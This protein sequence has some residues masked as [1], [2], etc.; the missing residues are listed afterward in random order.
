MNRF[1]SLFGSERFFY[2]F[3]EA[4][5]SRIAR[6][7][8]FVRIVPHWLLPPSQRF[9]SSI[10]KAF[11]Q[12]TPAGPCPAQSSGTANPARRSGRGN[13]TR[14]SSA[15][16]RISSLRFDLCRMPSLG[17]LVKSS[18]TSCLCRPVF[19]IGVDRF[20]SNGLM[21]WGACVEQSRPISC[22]G[23]ANGARPTP[24]D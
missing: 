1:L 3:S 17:E 9:A 14:I 18:L 15:G 12:N 10:G 23:Q 20:E 4:R 8:H 11:D 7:A 24:A 2:F 6:Q 22:L 21:A 5:M 16:C 13:A 19:V